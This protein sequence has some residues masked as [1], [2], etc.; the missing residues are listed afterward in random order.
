MATIKSYTSLEQSRKLAEILSI[1]SADMHWQY[2]EEDN[3][4]LQ[5]F[6]FPKDFSINQHNMVSAWSLTALLGVLPFPVLYMEMLGGMILWSCECHF[7][8]TD[9]VVKMEHYDNPVDACVAMIEQL[10]ELNLL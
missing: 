9:E 10:H 6:C 8:E 7:M 3:G 4:Q 1:E 5:W 2:I